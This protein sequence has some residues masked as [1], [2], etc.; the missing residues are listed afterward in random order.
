MQ[1]STKLGH[2]KY[3]NGPE[4]STWKMANCG[5]TPLSIW[6]IAKPSQKG[7]DQRHHLQFAILGSLDPIFYTINKANIITD[8]LENQFRAHDFCNCDHRWHVEAQVKVLL[9]TGDKDTPVNFQPCDVSK[10]TQSLK[11][12]NA[13]GF[14]GI[15]N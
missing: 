6:P 10:E 9:A 7:V 8:C 13:C 3:E 15:P 2:L 5:V 14:D 12:W 1:N 11:L 4:K